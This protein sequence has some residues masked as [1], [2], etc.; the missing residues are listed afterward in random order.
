M[1]IITNKELKVKSF[2]TKKGNLTSKQAE[3]YNKIF[4]NIIDG[5]SEL[6]DLYYALNRIS[7]FLE[8]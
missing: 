5:K 3:L 1:F 8:K 6:L 7:F 2:T 4:N